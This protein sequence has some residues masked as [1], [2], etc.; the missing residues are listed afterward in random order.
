MAEHYPS[1]QGCFG[2]HLRGRFMFGVTARKREGQGRRQGLVLEQGR[3][4]LLVEQFANL[5]ALAG[6]CGAERPYCDVRAKVD[7]SLCPILSQ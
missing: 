3:V 1:I 2:D 6:T 5:C 7:L 4:L